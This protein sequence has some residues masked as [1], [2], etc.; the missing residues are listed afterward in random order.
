MAAFGAAQYMNMRFGFARTNREHSCNE[1]IVKGE[2]LAADRASSWL[3]VGYG[4]QFGEA[5]GT[6]KDMHHTVAFTGEYCA[7]NA[8]P[9]TQRGFAQRAAAD[10]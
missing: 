5:V 6:A 7:E 9:A 10:C 3:R 4:S 2:L 1:I 8:A